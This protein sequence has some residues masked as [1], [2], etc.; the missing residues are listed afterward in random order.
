MHRAFEICPLGLVHDYDGIKL[1]AI[2]SPS[3][4]RR[5]WLVRKDEKQQM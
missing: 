4:G 3:I 5:K 2:P 1:L